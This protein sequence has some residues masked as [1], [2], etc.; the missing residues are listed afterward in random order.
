MKRLIALALLT[1]SVLTL[2]SCSI[3]SNGVGRAT[4]VSLLDAAQTELEKNGTGEVMRLDDAAVDAYEAALVADGAVLVADMTGVLRVTY[5]RD[6]G[7]LLTEML[8]F[9]DTEDTETVARY[10]EKKYATEIAEGR[11]RVTRN[12]YVLTVT[13]ASV[14]LG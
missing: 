1:L 13:C 10:Y 3:L 5:E 9:E 4:S 8:G 12:G 6:N 2:T 14:V 11:A 7:S